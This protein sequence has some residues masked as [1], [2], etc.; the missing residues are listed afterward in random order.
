MVIKR[1]RGIEKNLTNIHE[2]KQAAQ[3]QVLSNIGHK[4][5]A[6]DRRVPVVLMATFTSQ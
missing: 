5:S 6:E 2:Q 4:G 1:E 3:T